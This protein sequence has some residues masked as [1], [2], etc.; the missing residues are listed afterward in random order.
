MKRFTLLLI[1]ASLFAACTGSQPKPETPSEPLV[2]GDRDA[3]GCIPSAGYTWCEPK[4][5][6]LRM[7]EEPCFA[8]AFEAIV[9]ELAQRHGNAQEQISLTIAEQT[10]THARASVRFG[11]E[12]TPGGLVLAAQKNGI[13]RIVFEGNG[14]VDCA[15][16]RAEDFPETMLV[17]ICD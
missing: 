9:W 2:G 11:P 13:W 7:W 3:H 6:C 5:K 15:A 10:E 12:G 4:Q 1:A 8:S 14:S 16:L 17:G